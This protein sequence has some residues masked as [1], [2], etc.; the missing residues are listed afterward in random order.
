MEPTTLAKS[1]YLSV[2]AVSR[3]DDHGGD[4]TLRTQFFVNG[5]LAQA[6]RHRLAIELILVEWNPP[7]DQPRLGQLLVF[8]RNHLWLSVRLVEV[9][10][11][12]HAR[13][14]H[15][16]HLPLYQMI[17][18]NVGIRRA[19][20]QFVLCTNVD[21]LFS[22]PLFAYLAKRSL[23]AGKYYRSIRRDTTVLTQLPAINPHIPMETILSA[24][25]R[26]LLRVNFQNVS[27]NMQNGE[28][29]LIYPPG[30][31]AE[32]FGH[33]V[34]FTNACGDFTLLSRE[35]FHRLHGYAELDMFSFHLDA[36]FLYAAHYAGL[37]EVILPEAMGHYHIEHGGG[38]TPEIHK[39]GSLDDRLDTLGIPRLDNAALTDMIGRL[40]RGELPPVGNGPSWGLADANLPDTPVTVAAWDVSDAS[41]PDAPRLSIV[42]T[43]RNDDHGG[44]IKERFQTFLT[45][46]GGICEHFALDAEL[47][48]VEWNPDPTFGPLRQAM[49]WPD[50]KHLRLRLITVPPRLHSTFGNAEK[51]PLFQ[52]IAKNVGVRR[53]RGSFVLCTNVDVL[54]SEEL[55][56]W[57]ARG[58]LSPDCLYRID[59]HDIGATAIP[60]DLDLFGRLAFCRERVVRVH[61]QFGTHPPDAPGRGDP[62]KLHTEACGDFTLM[63]RKRWLE[64]EGYPEFHLWS[65]YI[66]GLVVHAARASGMPQVILADP[67]RMYHIE[68]GSGWA[69]D[70]TT[71][72]QFPSVDYVGL[73]VPLCRGMLE[74]KRPLR[75]NSPKWGLADQNLEE[76]SPPRTAVA[77]PATIAETDRATYRHW[78]DILAYR[79]NRL[80]YRDQ[81]SESLVALGRLARDFDPTVIVELGTLGGLSLRAWLRSAP[82]ARVTA[83]DLS[84]ATLRESINILPLDL[85][86]ITLLEADIMTVDFSSLWG[87]G[88][89]VLFFVDAH[90]LPNIPIMGHVLG[91][92]VPS[93]PPGSLMVVDD[94]WHSPVELSADTA[95]TFL[96]EKVREEIDWLQCF[97]AHYAPYH[98]GGS[99]LG[100]RE[101]VP[102][103][104]YVNARGI[105][106]RF[107]GK[108]K[109]ASFV[110]GP[111]P[112]LPDY[113][114]AGFA[115]RCGTVLHNPLAGSVRGASFVTHTMTRI[116]AL[117]RKAGPEA[118]TSLLE[119]LANK[120]P[121]ASGLAYALAVC[122]AR[123]GRPA[124]AMEFL[125]HELARPTPHP[126]AAALLGD[127]ARN[128]LT[129]QGDD[130]PRRPGLTLFAM[131]KAFV[132]HMATIQRNALESWTRL[133]P[134]P[135]IILFGDEPGIAET[136]AALG[137]RHEPRVGR[138]DYGTPLVDA[139]FGAAQEI[140]ETDV[141]AYVNADIV[142]FDDFPAAVDALRGRL[143]EFL[144]VGRR[145][146]FDQLRPIDFARADWAEKLRRHVGREGVLHAETG[147]DYF[148]FTPGLW[149]KIPPFA[150]GR[151]A[152]DNWLVMAPQMLG[153]SV[154][155]ATDAVTAVHQDHD[156]GH[157]TG[158]RSFVFTG[159][160][161]RR[162]KL[163][164][165]PV[166]DRGFTNG[167]GLALG[168][169]G[170]LTPRP[171]QSASFGSPT[172]KKERLAWLLRR[173]GR[174]LAAG[175]ADLAANK[176]EEGLVLVPDH[177]ELTALR[178]L[179]RKK[180]EAAPMTVSLVAADPLPR[181]QK[182]SAPPLRLLQLSTFYGAYLKQ[183]YAEHPELTEA[184]YQTQGRALE[185]DG[186][187]GVHM[188]AP[189]LG[190]L[191]YQ[192]ELIVANNPFSQ[193]AWAREHGLRP[194]AQ[195]NFDLL[196]ILC[197]QV[198]AYRPQVLYHSDPILLDSR[199]IRSLTH[200]PELILGWR[201]ADIP[202]DWDPSE[203]DVILSSLSTLRQKALAMGAKNAEHFYPG[204]PKFLLQHVGGVESDVD[205]VFAGQ[206][207]AFQ[208]PRRNAK[209]LA[210]ARAAHSG[211][212]GCRFHL[213]GN[214]AVASPEVR[215]LDQGPVYGRRM[216][217]AVRRGRIAFDARG[218][219]GLLTS[220]N[221]RID[222]A[223]TQTANMRIFEATG[224]GAFLLTEHFSNI[225]DF[226]I[227]GEEIE[228]F[229]GKKEMIDKVR[230]YLDNPDKRREI[231]E[232][233]HRRCLRDYSM[234]A[235]VKDF[236]A[237]V[238]RH[239][240]VKGSIHNDAR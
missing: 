144:M 28:R 84:F 206:V 232:R 191:G 30:A 214:L 109:N 21:V 172:Y 238:R 29:H 143:P 138:N 23:E 153:K 133:T 13:F 46:L 47:I 43:M 152:W 162:N 125:G 131:P 175:W 203:F 51:F 219:I 205:L 2:V 240:A 142:L 16:N 150:I 80:Y 75:V 71:H 236:D 31:T 221:K 171:P 42:V 124:Q 163:L 98:G 33:P 178:E 114:A 103:L 93:L 115:S 105:A 58:E 224:L 122:Q 199:F 25:E 78:I 145:F 168:A 68:H 111:G 110:T 135:E 63:S 32:T 181:P 237:I 101:V 27:V 79:D 177:P 158:G 157:R 215:A 182:E 201:A 211:L 62:D 159:I 19:R 60:G 234:E 213:S 104:D 49:R 88:D 222:L 34:L 54:F 5:L 97:E 113:D 239:L 91:T 52:M 17:A 24:C 190:L 167:A 209:L 216:H 212:F 94:L 55:A 186:F 126:A 57:L 118:A 120:E 136:A 233:G 231:A 14:A 56:D 59:R 180:L 15:A 67:L 200:R 210:L 220:N 174:L 4:L 228:T 185:Q 96:R 36:L 26:H 218:E 235:R 169:D 119:D 95:E 139:L 41:G 87:P 39:V 20:G 38:W 65:I 66:D 165:G 127:L 72:H 166:D 108:A 45:H 173:V 225:G 83:V 74:A 183:F 128:F 184:D 148:A 53:A 64:L 202:A 18:K 198:E 69:V 226:F 116:A 146:D 188:L 3:N 10:P 12:V 176:I 137:L 223:E 86:R 204:F 134:R 102:L 1:P 85:Y 11:A 227:P 22:D 6:E 197:A 81:T 90:D 164:C 151:T 112:V 154:V 50:A 156:Y 40:A 117:Y 37:E 194:D 207:N 82:E 193:F 187:G 229:A 208:Y 147:I 121:G 170:V 92:A 106:L 8:P 123:L 196:A 192:A 155:D 107:D 48:V 129:H 73:Y 44:N 160:E 195:G 77:P 161:A 70:Q 61:G 149:P 9:P 99:F 189:P 89:R 141:L 7:A 132:G 179:A 140:S 100:F 217:R 35:D 76:W 130:R 230:Y